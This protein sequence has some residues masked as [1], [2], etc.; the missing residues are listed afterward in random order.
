MSQAKILIIDDEEV[1]CDACAQVFQEEGYAVETSHEGKTGLKKVDEF[2]PDLVFVDLKMP[3]MSG[4]EVLEKL[5]EKDKEIVSIVITGYATIESAVDSMKHGAFD[6]L[7]KPFAP[8]ELLI[9]TKRALEKRKISLEAEFLRR[10]KEN[11]RQN[12]VSMVSHEMRT[13]LAAVIQ[14]LEVLTKG[15]AGTV[16]TEQA[17]IINRMKIRLNELLGLIDRWLKLARIEDLNMKE[18]FVDFSIVPLINES[19]DLM[20]PLAQE[21]N[22]EIGVKIPKEELLVHGDA[23]MI[24]EVFTNLIHN[25]IKYNQESGKVSIE[26]RQEKELLV[27]D[28]SDTGAGIP[29]NQVEYLGNEFYRVRREGGAVGTGL[30]LAIVKKILDIHNGRLAIKSELNKGSTFSVYLPQ[31]SKR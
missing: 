14:Y 18:N 10:E 12:F 3:G 6:F 1:I 22:V 26:L 4:I 28:F 2:K 15:F 23:G 11:M 17:N 24:K 5:R 13:P 29:A 31:V 27:I 8:E 9:I 19:V 16:S 30:G 7:P 25:G 21:K 20:R